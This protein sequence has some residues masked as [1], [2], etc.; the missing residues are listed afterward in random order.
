M[1]TI[2]RFA[3][4][5]IKQ[6]TIIVNGKAFVGKIVTIGPGLTVHVDGEFRGH[7]PDGQGPVTA[8]R[9]PWGLYTELTGRL[10]LRQNQWISF[11]P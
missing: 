5:L 3:R 10:D 9:G 2:A 6:Q 8:S 1:K 11:R 7:A 4:R